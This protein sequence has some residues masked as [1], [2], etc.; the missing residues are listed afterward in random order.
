MEACHNNGD[1]S[2]NRLSNLRW[3]TRSANQLDKQRHGTDH[4]S[5]KTHCPRG[6]SLVT[7]NLVR[8]QAA[9]G[10]RICLACSRAYS[11]VRYRGSLSKDDFQIESDRHY[12]QIMANV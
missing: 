12:D 6:H 7:P 2:D 9:K 3:D 8:C 1:A 4:N 11:N 5:S 10:F